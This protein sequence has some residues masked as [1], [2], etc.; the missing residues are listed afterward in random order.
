MAASGSKLNET[1]TPLWKIFSGE[2]KTIPPSFGSGTFVDVRDVAFEHVW[3]FENSSKADGQRY[4]ACQGFG[5]AQAIAD[6]LRETYKGTS[7]AEK[8][9]VGTP[10]EGYVGYN[11]ATGVVEDVGYPAGR[12]RVDGSKAS[13]AMGL[14]YITFKQSV[15]DTAKALEPLL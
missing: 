1:L 14:N 11:K 6:I 8:I 13:K 7:I 2:A 4:I 12:P 5:P 10:G 9:P 3:A 15:I